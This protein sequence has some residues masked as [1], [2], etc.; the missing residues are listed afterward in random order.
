MGDL[1][2]TQAMHVFY[3]GHVCSKEN[4]YL[5][6]MYSCPTRAEAYR[7]VASGVVEVAVVVNVGSLFQL[8]V[9]YRQAFDLGTQREFS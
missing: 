6:H 3:L 4:V 1:A 9:K 7:L 8:Q 2:R 5:Q